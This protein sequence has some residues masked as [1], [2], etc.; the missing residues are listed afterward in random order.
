MVLRRA[1]C[2]MS[3]TAEKKLKEAGSQNRRDAVPDPHKP[4][5]IGSAAVRI[6][7]KK[8]QPAMMRPAPPLRPSSVSRVLAPRRVSSFRRY[9]SQAQ[10]AQQAISRSISDLLKWRPAE[11]ADHV[12]VNGF[13]RSV[14]AMKTHR[15]VALGDGSSLA[16]LQA[17]VEADHA[18]G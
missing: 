16:P 1:A 13:V 15:F 12:V 17:L 18:E 4:A 8:Q 11:Q 3:R 5:W 6:T 9:V 14:R 10:Q 2:S 7:A